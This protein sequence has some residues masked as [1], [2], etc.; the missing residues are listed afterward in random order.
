MKLVSTA[1]A[2]TCNMAG[3]ILECAGHE[4]CRELSPPRKNELSVPSA[5]NSKGG[6]GATFRGNALQARGQKSALPQEIKETFQGSGNVRRVASLARRPCCLPHTSGS[7]TIPF[8]S[9]DGVTKNTA[10]VPGWKNN[11][12]INSTGRVYSYWVGNVFYLPG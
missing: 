7:G 3:I 10:V 8:I 1:A 4:R 2:E 11:R 5:E 6:G 9:R 12:E